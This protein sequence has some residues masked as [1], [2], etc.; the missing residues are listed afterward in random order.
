[1]RVLHRMGSLRTVVAVLTVITALQMTLIALGNITDYETNHQ[2]VVHVFAM[3]TTFKSPHLMWRSVTNP[4][5]VTS[6]YVLIIAWETIA[7]LVLIAAVVAWVRALGGRGTTDTAR[8][9]STLGWLMWLVLFAGGFIAV[10][11]EYFQ[12]WQ[13]SKWNGLQSALQNIIIA[14]FALIIANLPRARENTVTT[15]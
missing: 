14:S 5:L 15:D 3:D 11:G 7:A 13:S 9:L 8:R 2:F 12:M 6:A 10:G 4:T 1:M